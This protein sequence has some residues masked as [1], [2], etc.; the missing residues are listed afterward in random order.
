[1]TSPSRI[2]RKTKKEPSKR[3]LVNAMEAAKAAGWTNVQ[4]RTPYGVLIASEDMGD[5][6]EAQ[7]EWD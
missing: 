5:G 6:K 2:S 7:G 4:I 3:F 1:M